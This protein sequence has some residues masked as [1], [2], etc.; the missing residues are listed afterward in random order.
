[1]VSS[2]KALE[3][4]EAKQKL[5]SIQ[6]PFPPSPGIVHPKKE[7]DVQECQASMDKQGDCGLTWEKEESL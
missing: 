3:G 6:R 4:C 2:D 1:M 7:G 5:V